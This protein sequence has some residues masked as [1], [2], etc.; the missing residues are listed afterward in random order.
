M[1]DLSKI[2]VTH[3]QM[4]DV[5]Y[6]ARF[7]KKPDVVLD[8]REAEADVMIAVV[9]HM[10]HDAPNGSRK[11]VRIADGYFELTCRQIDAPASH[12]P[13]K[14]GAAAVLDRQ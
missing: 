9:Q 1:T 6:L 11:T 10:M 14:P 7:G 8:K 2:R 5:I 12:E 13:W 4:T 3:S